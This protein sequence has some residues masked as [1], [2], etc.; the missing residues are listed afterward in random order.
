[1]S[2]FSNLVVAQAARTLQIIHR[3]ENFESLKEKLQLA[4]G[5]AGYD[6]LRTFLFMIGDKGRY[7]RKEA[8]T[9]LA[10]NNETIGFG[11]TSQAAFGY[12]FE[13]FNLIFSNNTGPAVTSF[14]KNNAPFSQYFLSRRNKRSFQTQAAKYPEIDRL[15]IRDY[16]LEALHHTGKS[17][18]DKMSMF[19]STSKNSAT[20]RDFATSQS[21]FGI[22]IIGWVP[23]TGHYHPSPAL[24]ARDIQRILQPSKLP[25]YRKPFYRRQ[26]E[27]ALKGG[28]LAH[29]MVGFARLKDQTFELNP[30]LFSQTKPVSEILK[31]GFDIDQRSFLDS[32]RD[33]DYAGF[34]VVDELGNYWGTL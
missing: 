9:K 30:A 24:K 27:V 34:Y 11:D 5:P 19:V 33:T 22:I 29:F 10:V 3:G 16:Y 4:D 6:K 21:E 32:L 14:I 26:E 1:M 23:L 12:I 31:E 28:F 15:L 20:A 8:R 13:K 18:L 7:F 2:F 25:K 17:G